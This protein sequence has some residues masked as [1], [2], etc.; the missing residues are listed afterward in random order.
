MSAAQL[1]AWL[2]Q[3]KTTLIAV[4]AAG[5]V[6]LGLYKR[7]KSGDA[8]T[9][10]AGK[11][12]AAAPQYSAGGQVAAATGAAAYDSTSSDLFAALSPQL[13][14][15]GAQLGQLNNAQATPPTPVPASIA[16]SLYNPTKAPGTGSY[17]RY[18]DGTIAEIEDDGSLYGIS[19]AEP[20][21]WNNSKVT[22]LPWYNYQAGGPAY[23]ERLLNLMAA[24]KPTA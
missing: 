24:Q 17:V 13:D 23:S 7:K 21:D 3:N 19:A 12:A 6:G 4:G 22:Q 16:S 18:Q 20:F 1:E 2:T 9:D 8:G 11:A 14:A 15:I 10:P 5:A